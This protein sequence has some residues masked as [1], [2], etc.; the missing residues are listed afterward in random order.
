MCMRYCEF[1]LE[2][3]QFARCSWP[4]ERAHS[5][6][7]CEECK[8]QPSLARLQECEKQPSGGMDPQRED[9]RK[10]KYPRGKGLWIVSTCFWKGMAVKAFLFELWRTR[11]Q[12][13]E[14]LRS[15]GAAH[16]RE[17]GRR[18]CPAREVETLEKT[19][20]AT[21]GSGLPPQDPGTEKPPQADGQTPWCRGS[22]FDEEAH[23]A[24]AAAMTT[25]ARPPQETF[26]RLGRRGLHPSA[27]KEA[28][29]TERKSGGSAPRGNGWTVGGEPSEYAR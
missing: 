8:K 28:W 15:T 2:E 14:E 24:V 21:T 12:F 5:I 29:W 17:H 1:C 26:E 4:N 16:V 27:R 13:Q 11:G 22:T 9:R 19:S 6:H 3:D 25:V 23:A 20:F 7:M 10:I 18:Q